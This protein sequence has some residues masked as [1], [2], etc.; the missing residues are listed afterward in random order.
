MVDLYFTLAIGLLI[1]STDQLH[2]PEH[3]KA[4]VELERGDPKLHVVM[5]D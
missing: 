3:F 2:Y 1:A 5:H 4:P